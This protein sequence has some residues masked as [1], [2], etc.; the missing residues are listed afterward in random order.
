MTDI[1][2]ANWIYHMPKSKQRFKKTLH[3]SGHNSDDDLY[4][5]SSAAQLSNK[6]HG[7]LSSLPLILI[8]GL[9]GNDP[10]IF[11]VIFT[12]EDGYTRVNE[13]EKFYFK[14]MFYPLVDK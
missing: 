5:D 3:F 8:L 13:V 6:Q 1:I 11:R 9:D 12:E 2:L 7:K 14:E 4:A 10:Q